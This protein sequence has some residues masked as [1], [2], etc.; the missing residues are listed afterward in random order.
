MPVPPWSLILIAMLV[1]TQTMN[2]SER[3]FL[4]YRSLEHPKWIP[5]HLWIPAAWFALNIAF[6]I[7]AL[8]VWNA[9]QDWGLVA[10]YMGLLI[11]LRSHP[12]FI[13]RLRS[14]PAGLPFWLA[15][16]LATLILA[17]VVRPLSPLAS[18]LLV[19]ILVWTP[20]EAAITVRMIGLNRKANRS[21]RG[22]DD[23][24][25]ARSRRL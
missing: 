13:C 16:W 23:R 21:G 24:R 22:P 5:M 1:V 12:W 20:V 10:A 3:D 17:L 9:T 25:P 14:L 2:P 11:L 8:S 6:Y 19:P 4:W 15:S 7:S 18:W